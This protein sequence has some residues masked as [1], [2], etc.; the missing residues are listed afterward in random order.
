[1]K[2]REVHPSDELLLRGLDGELEGEVARE[3]SGHV[4]GC[5]ECRA[6][7]RSMERVSAAVRAYGKR[8]EGDAPGRA[9]SAPYRWMAIAAALVMAAGIWTL[10][11][12]RPQAAVKAERRSIADGFIALP[13]S[14]ENLSSEGA[15]VLQ[16]ELPPTAL[17][18]AGMPVNND[19][20]GGKV[21]AEVLVGADGLARGIRFL[22]P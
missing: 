1:M 18:L 21:R 2:E 12:V 19:R 17:L 6:R 16:V 5:A 11:S 7:L 3:V 15:V 13:Y 9:R 22:S 10:M 4:P 8:L 14:D 20:P